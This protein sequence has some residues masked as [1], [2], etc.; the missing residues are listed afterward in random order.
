[1]I[2]EYENFW[3]KTHAHIYVVVVV[4]VD[5][6]IEKEMSTYL[7]KDSLVRIAK[8]R[9]FGYSFVYIYFQHLSHKTET[10]LSVFNFI[11]EISVDINFVT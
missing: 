5:T 11:I 1:M 4:V 2:D 9:C 7:F 8:C 3:G 10:V 6:S